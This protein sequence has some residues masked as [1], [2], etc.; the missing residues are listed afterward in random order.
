VRSLRACVFVA[1]SAA[2]G[3]PHE[4]PATVAETPRTLPDLEVATELSIELVF[5]RD[6]IWLYA[7]APALEPTCGEAVFP[8]VGVCT[9]WSDGAC[10]AHLHGASLAPCLRVA[11]LVVQRS[12]ERIPFDTHGGLSA[13][14]PYTF[15][16][17]TDALALHLEGCA[18]STTIAL[19]RPNALPP[20]IETIEEVAGETVVSL[21]ESPAWVEKK[22][23]GLEGILCGVAPSDEVHLAAAP[24]VDRTLAAVA[25][26]GTFASEFGAVHVSQRFEG[27]REVL[28]VPQERTALLELPIVEDRYFHF[29]QLESMTL[30]VDG[31]VALHFIAGA[32]TV[33]PLRTHVTLGSFEHVVE[34]G[35]GDGRQM[36]AVR[37]AQVRGGGV[38]RFEAFS[39]IWRETVTFEDVSG[40]TPPVEALLWLEFDPGVAIVPID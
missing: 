11:E 7:R 16:P 23:S 17:Y 28:T 1:A 3:A 33:E 26:L 15:D 5:A 14:E 39:L 34:R 10:D 19:P 40:E 20:A 29:G 38:G 35:Y 6:A 4:P 12:G 8:D 2:C 31:T 37:P 13:I 36:R 30:D 32:A 21:E 25:P 24:G 22:S 9:Q 27:V 18:L